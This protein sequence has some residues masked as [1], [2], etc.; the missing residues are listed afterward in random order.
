MKLIL[1]LF[2]IFP[3]KFA[4]TIFL[5]K[6]VFTG[7]RGRRKTVKGELIMFFQFKMRNI[8][9]SQYLFKFDI[10]ICTQ[11]FD[12]EL[13]DRVQVLSLKDEQEDVLQNTKDSKSNA[14]STPPIAS[15]DTIKEV[16]K[17][18]LKNTRRNDEPSEEAIN[19]AMK[20]F[21]ESNKVPQGWYN[22][23]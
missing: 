21:Q 5:R 13:N 17:H 10:I 8:S 14:R 2:L 15:V 20:E 16:I 1:I 6:A 9:V 23:I 11:N 19:E 7:T 18:V 12:V 4:E 22:K 3:S